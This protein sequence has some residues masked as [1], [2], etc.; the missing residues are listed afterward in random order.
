ME[1]P[2]RENDPGGQGRHVSAPSPEN[3][4]GAHGLQTPSVD[5]FAYDPAG[6]I[7]HKDNP[8]VEAPYP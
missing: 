8:G 2:V 7:V 3:S 5:E 1:Y 6:H 4:P